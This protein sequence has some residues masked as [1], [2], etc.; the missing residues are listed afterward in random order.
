MAVKAA[1]TRRVSVRR[2]GLKAASLRRSWDQRGM[3]RGRGIIRDGRHDCQ[4][5]GRACNRFQPSWPKSGSLTKLLTAWCCTIHVQE[6][7]ASL[8]EMLL[9]RPRVRNVAMMYSIRTGGRLLRE[10]HI[11][12]ILS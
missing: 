6:S 7:F 11:F 12:K 3:S 8:S 9:M 4:L 10:L 2:K 1:C 5:S